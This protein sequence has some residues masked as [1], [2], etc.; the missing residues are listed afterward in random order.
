MNPLIDYIEK[1]VDNL[2]KEEK[3]LVASDRKDEANLVKIRINIYNIC[4]T[5]YQ[6]VEKGKTDVARVYLEKLDN[7]SQS[8]Q[9]SLAKAKEHQDVEKAVIEE[10][11]LETLG[12]IRDRF[13]E[14]RV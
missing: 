9:E 13:L 11:K 1:E 7:L 10:M 12:K 3:E 5:I 2:Q 6:V 4:A 8:W 14:W